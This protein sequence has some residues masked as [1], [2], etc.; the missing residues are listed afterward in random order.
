MLY[1][2]ISP[3]IFGGLK[4]LSKEPP[5]SNME[6]QSLLDKDKSRM[7]EGMEKDLKL[8]KNFIKSNLWERGLEKYMSNNLQ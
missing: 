5:S 1:S 4:V 3:L 2:S 8:Q 6:M 7:T